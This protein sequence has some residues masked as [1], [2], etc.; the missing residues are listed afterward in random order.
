MYV[1]FPGLNGEDVFTELSASPHLDSVAHHLGHDRHV[2]VS[3]E[4]FLGNVWEM[5]P[6]APCRARAI[7]DFSNQ[8]TDVFEIV[9]YLRPQYLWFESLYTQYVQE[10]Q[11]S[12][13]EKFLEIM[14]SSRYTY[15]ASLVKDLLGV[16]GPDHLV[17]RP[18]WDDIDVVQDFATVIGIE[19]SDWGHDDFWLNASITPAQVPILRELNRLAPPTMSQLARH[20][21]QGISQSQRREQ[22]PTSV[23]PEEWQERLI[24]LTLSDWN[25][26]SGLVAGIR[27]TQLASVDKVLESARQAKVRPQVGSSW[28]ESAVR[29]GVVE[30]LTVALEK[31]NEPMRTR[32]LRRMREKMAGSNWW[33]KIR[34]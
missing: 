28:D 10:G 18:Y 17:I 3:S 9:I 1:D 19:Q 20:F 23:L 21:L 32:T 22:A 8:H 15:F 14:L 26:L 7:R 29:E 31:V 34:R 5:Y 24:Q 11:T 27:H 2:I 16:L 6:D 25:Q 12:C 13:P 4:G 30:A 33:H